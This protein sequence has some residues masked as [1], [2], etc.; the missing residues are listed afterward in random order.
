MSKAEKDAKKIEDKEHKSLG[1]QKGKEAKAEAKDQ[2]KITKDKAKVKEEKAGS[3]DYAKAQK[4][5]QKDQANLAKDKSNDQ[6]AVQKIKDGEKKDLAKNEQKLVDNMDKAH[7][8]QFDANGQAIHH[9]STG[10]KFVSALEK[11]IP[12]GAGIAEA[13]ASMAGPEGEAIAPVIGAGASIV[14]GILDPVLQAHDGSNHM[15]KSETG[16]QAQQAMD[17]RG[18][19]MDAYEK[20]VQQGQKSK[21]DLVFELQRRELHGELVRTWARL[22]AREAR[23][24]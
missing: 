3:K 9:K 2:R 17:H 23:S 24:W 1:K 16:Q 14:E 20:M 5:L 21:R 10:E 13:G 11:I 15:M 19:D 22:M 7:D 18:H 4:S 6:K 8:K 12:I